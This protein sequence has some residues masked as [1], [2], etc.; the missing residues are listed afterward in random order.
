MQCAQTHDTQ[1]GQDLAL[2]VHD[3]CQM[4]G[5]QLQQCGDHVVDETESEVLQVQVEEGKQQTAAFVQILNSIMA[6]HF[7]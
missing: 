5:G 6:Q 7:L 1:A 3:Q 4:A 2:G